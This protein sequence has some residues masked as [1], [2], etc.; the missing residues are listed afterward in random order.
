MYIV[1]SS[2]AFAKLYSES[3]CTIDL[4][5]FL[6]KTTLSATLIVNIFQF[7]VASV[8]HYGSL[9]RHAQYGIV[10]FTVLK[11]KIGGD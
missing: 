2:C 1:M 3:W 5:Y 6:K 9:R 10:P 8:L 4:I 7:I 11:L